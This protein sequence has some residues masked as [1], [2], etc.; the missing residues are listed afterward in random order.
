ML[1]AGYGMGM[2]DDDGMSI[3]DAIFRAIEKIVL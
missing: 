3:E 1:G 2:D